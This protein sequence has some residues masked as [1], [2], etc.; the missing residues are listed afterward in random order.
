MSPA[1]KVE[2][3]FDYAHVVIANYLQPG[4]RDAEASMGE[5]IG[6]L[7]DRDLF[8][9]IVELLKARDA[10]RRW[11]QPSSSAK[12]LGSSPVSTIITKIAFRFAEKFL[13]RPKSCPRNEV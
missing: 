3:S 4:S 6:V 2:K 5:M 8:D 10:N 9:A 13:H 7:D 1:E 12:P 11:H